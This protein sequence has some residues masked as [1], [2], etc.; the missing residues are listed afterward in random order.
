MSRHQRTDA[1]R[2]APLTAGPR[3]Y[4]RRIRTLGPL[5]GTIPMIVLGV[6]ALVALQVGNGRTSGLL[7]LFLGAAAARGCSSP[8]PVR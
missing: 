1:P 5:F 8:A 7:G 4:K 3:W 6:V 2:T